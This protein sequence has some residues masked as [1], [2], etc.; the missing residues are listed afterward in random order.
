VGTM[1]STP[2]LHIHLLGQ[3][4]FFYAHEP[5][6]FVARPK[7]LALLAYLLLHRV[8][9]LSREK[10]AFTLWDE[11]SEEEARANLRRHLPLLHSALPPGQPEA[12][13]IV[14]DADT[15]QWNPLAPAWLDVAEFERLAA[16]P[17]GRA[18]AADLYT[19]ELLDTSYDEW[20]FAERDRLR[21]VYLTLLGALLIECRGQR[22][23]ARA[24]AYAQRI[25]TNDPWREDTL[26]QLMAI[27]YESGDRA[28]ALASYHQFERR[29]REEMNVDLMPESAALRDVI[30]ANEPLPV[31]VPSGAGA[32]GR[33]GGAP[34]LPFVGRA[35]EM[36]QLLEQW[37]RAARGRGNV[38][39]IAGEAGIGKSRLASEFA[40]TAEV[41]GG[42]VMRGGTS[43]PESAP[44]QALAEAFRGIAPLLASLPVQPIWLGAIAQVVPE[45][46]SRIPDLPKPPSV[47]PDRERGRLFE[48][49]AICLEALSKPRPLVLVLEDMHW[50]GEA[51]I[52]ALQYIGRKLAAEPII[53][54]ATY[55]DEE[56]NRSHPLRRLRRQLQEDSVL[57]TVA[58]RMLQ[59]EAVAQ[60]LESMPSVL[61][62]SPDIADVLLERSAGNPLFLGEF[63]HVLLEGSDLMSGQLP[64]NVKHAI[65]LRA[66]KLTE[67]SRALA[68][69]AAVIGHG[70]NVDLVRDVAG[71]GENDVL[72]ALNGLIDHHFVKETSGR[73]GYDFAFSHHLIHSTIYESVPPDARVRR[74][75]RAARALEARRQDR[76]GQFAADV[77]R[78][79][80]LGGERDL[81]GAAYLEAGRLSHEVYA[82]D[83]ALRDL[84]RTLELSRDP[85]VRKEALRLRE[86]IRALRGDRAGQAEDL[87]AL[88]RIAGEA[89]DAELHCD[90]LRRK[91]L[92][93]RALGERDRER[94][95]VLEFVNRAAE[96][97]DDRL[98]A[99]SLIAS[100]AYETLAGN[101][102]D[103]RTAA[104]AALELYRG[105]GDAAG[106]IEARCRLIEL[107]WEG[108]AFDIASKMLADIRGSAE[109][110]GYQRL[111]GRA[112]TSATHA[113]LIE[114]RYAVCRDLAVEARQVYRL[115]GDREGE[116]DVILRQASAAAR[117]SLLEEAR[118][119]YAEA[120]AIYKSI[121]KRLGVAAVL[122]NAGI[123]SVR[124]GLLDEAERSLSEA[125]DHFKA[126]KDV[127]GQTACAVNLSYV[128]LI[129]GDAAEA[130]RH[131]LKGMEFARTIA[132]AGY[133]A[134]A[135][136]N[137][138]GAE[139]DLGNLEAAVEHMQAGISIRRRSTGA[140]ADY[141][142]DLANLMWVLVL[143]GATDS[144]RALGDELATALHELSPA[145]FMPQFA[146]FAAAQA[147]RALGERARASDALKMAYAIVDEQAAAIAGTSER[148][149]FLALSV[150]SEIAAAFK[151]KAWPARPTIATTARPSK[152]GRQRRVKDAP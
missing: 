1:P 69:V 147:F 73:G 150:N 67:S 97:H 85:E 72:D 61:H 82:F 68:D 50:A 113:A 2:S 140:A 99:A 42:R 39:T 54:I 100:A 18:E 4:R 135:L 80:D 83:E 137:L 92:L 12:P 105:L 81:A 56:V 88:D 21:N 65:A 43:D 117:L 40:L 139:R 101:H 31:V 71:W 151:R 33:P 64:A 141:A 23:F 35:A 5:F 107:A 119:C 48:A 138:G 149:A 123:H 128:H 116:A 29:L 3:P 24:G 133:E 38:V 36:A 66:S 131:A 87:A 14:A 22:D 84:R 122:A 118:Q 98:R 148:A 112:F 90:L 32:S 20:V 59:R 132:H 93:A 60:L 45:L 134:A 58:P 9:P 25:L 74:H 91:T 6:K 109:A 63:I 76:P 77:A 103:A 146:Y 144:A 10:V 53:V 124:L 30:L 108:G 94:V 8:G 11:D 102:A 143:A 16:A 51:S 111:V 106:Q 78:H 70:F 47:D 41:Q 7:V 28:G 27:R 127:R 55:R 44:Y 136:G 89:G 115:I 75:R 46:R 15:V 62:A 142:D 57:S 96:S 19:G 110:A 126:L 120:T 152:S 49:F 104:T 13:W 26:R 121:G 17:S 145:I 129:R 34:L 86:S 130:K 79:Y 114:Q 52:A 125:G 95:L 37:N